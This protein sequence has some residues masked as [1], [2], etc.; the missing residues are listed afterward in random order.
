MTASSNP[1]D[2]FSKPRRKLLENLSSASP[3]AKQT[4]Q[5]KVDIDIDTVE[6]IRKRE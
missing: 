2:R 5:R 3:K 1:A 4:G 6:Y